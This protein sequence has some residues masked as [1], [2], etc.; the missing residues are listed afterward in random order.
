MKQKLIQKIKEYGTVDINRF[1]YRYNS[2][3][4]TIR[5]IP[6]NMLYARKPI[7]EWEVAHKF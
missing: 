4:R 7:S 2:L 6:L 1:R 5:K 3:D